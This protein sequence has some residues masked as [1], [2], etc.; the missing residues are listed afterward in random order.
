MARKTSPDL[1]R[2]LLSLARRVVA[3]L[4]K[5]NV[6]LVLAESCT[7][8]LVAAVLTRIPGVSQF[9]CGSAVVY[10]EATKTRWLGVPAALLRRQGAVSAGVAVRMATGAL[11]ATPHADVA[12]AVTGY[13]GPDAPPSLDGVIYVALAK[14]KSGGRKP[15]VATHRFHLAQEA[16]DASMKPARRRL[17]RQR[18]AAAHVLSDLLDQLAGNN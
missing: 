10:Q 12:A 18:S 7:G 1:E 6:Q 11:R 17:R 9:L 3:G 2:R 8:G 4:R 16:G 5:G 13:L 14:R 15:L